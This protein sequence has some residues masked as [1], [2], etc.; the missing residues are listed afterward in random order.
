MKTKKHENNPVL[1]GEHAWGDA[2]QLILFVIFLIVWIADSFFL[3]YSTLRL[4][5]FPLLMRIA[6]AFIIFA[7]SGNLASKGLKIVFKENR[8][9]PEVIKKG[10]FRFVRHPIYL[11][12]ILLYTGFLV[13]S[14]SLLSTLVWFIVIV[15]YYYIARYEEKI[16]IVE[17]GEEYLQYPK[18]VSM[19][20]PLKFKLL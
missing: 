1:T 15:F 20:F 11:A 13:I 7:F 14:V 18:E 17:F 3:N 2:G 16:L 6:T 10:P 4:E 8:E 5:S 19:L 12:S 9:K